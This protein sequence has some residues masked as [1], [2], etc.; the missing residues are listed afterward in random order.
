MVLTFGAIAYVSLYNAKLFHIIWDPVNVFFRNL[1][2]RGALTP[3]DLEKTELFGVSKIE[4]FNWKQLMDL[5]ACTRCGRCQDAC[6]ANFS[7]KAL[8]PKKVI[9]DLKNHLYEVYP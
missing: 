3:I 4:N 7:G 9:Q 8:N 6:P 1:G 2:P 5:D